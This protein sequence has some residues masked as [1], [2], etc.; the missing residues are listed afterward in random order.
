MSFA[1]KQA[2]SEEVF[3]II[4][5]ALQQAGYTILEGDASTVCVVAPDGITHFDII[6][7]LCT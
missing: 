1:D 2:F 3:D 5:P 6:L 7:E 4:E